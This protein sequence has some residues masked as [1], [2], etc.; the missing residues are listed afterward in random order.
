MSTP[1]STSNIVPSTRTRPQRR[2]RAEPRVF[3]FRRQSKLSRE[4]VRTMQIVQ[5]TFARG[6]GT[7]LA[8]QLRSLTS[9]TI[10][11]IEQQTYDE[12]VRDMPNPTLLTLLSLAPMSGAAVLQLPLDIAFCSV[13]LLLG[14][15]GAG[16]QPS[17]PLTEL[18]LQLMRGIIERALPELR[19]AL[20]PVVA[21]EPKIVGQESNPQFAQVAAPTDMVIVVAFDVRIE[22][23]TGIAT[24]CIPFSSMSPY[25]EA[26][27]A[28]SLYA[29]HTV[30]NVEEIRS[31]LTYH[32]T[33]T[34]VT[35]A[36]E[37]RSVEMSA[38]DILRLQVGD[39]I[40]LSH[41]V[42][43]VLTL[44]VDGVPTFDARI[45]RRNR[46]L[47]LQIAGTAD[48][49]SPDRRPMSYELPAQT[50]NSGD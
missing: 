26:L 50:S 1:S 46:R 12:Y 5:E 35:V 23:T 13:E 17:R 38:T 2:H 15:T 24:L 20:E 36:A 28:T 3:D 6:F 40:P 44:T 34:P 33:E 4:H 19:Y 29:N 21:I 39:V 37:F 22:S 14:G 41:R 30:S 47:A 31:Q 25:L 9:V 45:G 27:S 7:M 48:V 16:I 42:D 11:S 49:R 43:Q 18:E 10:R 32:L 8:S